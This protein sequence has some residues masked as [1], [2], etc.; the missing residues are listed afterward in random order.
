MI[1]LIAQHFAREGQG[2]EVAALLREMSAYCNSDAEPGCLLYIVNRSTENPHHFLIYEQYADEAALAIHA[3][4]PM[5]QETLV[6]KEFPLLEKRERSFW[7][8]VEG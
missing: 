2:E 3:E 4:T 8:V 1:V 5:F 7:E 6:A